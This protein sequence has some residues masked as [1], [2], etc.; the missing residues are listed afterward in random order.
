MV[1]LEDQKETREAKVFKSNIH[2]I[3]IYIINIIYNT[4][5]N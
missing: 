3:Q 1:F 2:Y 4:V 5:E